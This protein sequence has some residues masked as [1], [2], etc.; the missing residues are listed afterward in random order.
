ME[1]L[2]IIKSNA[3]I[4]KIQGYGYNYSKQR[5]IWESTKCAWNWI[6][7]RWGIRRSDVLQ[8]FPIWNT[9]HNNARSLMFGFGFWYFEIS[10]MRKHTFNQ[11]RKF[12]FRKRLWKFYQLIC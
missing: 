5:I 9:S 11:T 10:Y 7:I 6:I 3:L 12:L 4:R 2:G 1:K 8:R